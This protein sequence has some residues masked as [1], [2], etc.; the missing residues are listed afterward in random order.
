MKKTDIM[1]NWHIYFW[2]VKI[3]FNSGT[4]QTSTM[5]L[6]AKIVSN[7]NLKALTVLSK[8]LILDA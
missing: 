7:V 1:S 6:F 4:L 5:E 8:R 3:L 2:T